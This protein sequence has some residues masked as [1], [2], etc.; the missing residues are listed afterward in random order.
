MSEQISQE[1]LDKLNQDIENTTKK[2]VSDDTAKKIQE[3]REEAKKEAEKEMLINQRIKELEEEKEKLKADQISKEKEAS[4]QL[5][6]LKGKVDELTASKAVIKSESPFEDKEELSKSIDKLTPEQED[7]I[8][9]QSFEIFWE[10]SNKPR[11]TN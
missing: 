1:E 5:T 8:E 7:E 11:D 6:A 4:E 10:Q 3:A 2:L 9:R